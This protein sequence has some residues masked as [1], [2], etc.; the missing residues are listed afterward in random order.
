MK[1]QKETDIL[2]KLAKGVNQ[3]DGKRGKL[4]EVFEDSFEVKLC[5]NQ[6]F[7]L[8]KLRY[9][10]NNP[11]SGKWQLAKDVVSYPHSAAKFYEMGM[12][13]VNSVTSWMEIEGNGSWK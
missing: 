11:C 10:H 4:H 3:S 1:A 13:G 8:Q 9:I 5:S 12:E 2:E 6:R 7:L